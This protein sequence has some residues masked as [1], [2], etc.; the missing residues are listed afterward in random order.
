MSLSFGNFLSSKDTVI[1]ADAFALSMQQLK[2]PEHKRLAIAV[3]GGIDSMCLVYCALHYQH[4]KPIV[5]LIVD[6]GLRQ[7]S[8]TEAKWVASYLKQKGIEGHILRWQGDKPHSNIHQIARNERYKLL[9]DYCQQHNITALMVGHNR[10]DQAETVLMRIL[11]G[12]GITGLT[13]IPQKG[14]HNGI[15]ILRPLLHF[16]RAQIMA[17]M[18]EAAW[19]WIEDPS[20]HDPKYTRSVL[21]KWLMALP[22]P[23]LAVQRLDL[24]A[25]NAQR[26]ED[27]LQQQTKQFITASTA[28]IITKYGHTITMDHNAFSTAH[29]EIAL[30]VLRH[31]LL[32]VGTATMPPR[33]ERLMRLY[34]HIIAPPMA[35][36]TLCG[37]KIWV[38]QGVI[39]F[40]VAT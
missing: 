23:E 26:A 4:S 19:Q 24:L 15:A 5:A 21:R 10:N 18:K 34:Q 11:R 36:R 40:A 27:Y 17:T 35:A 16:T 28:V 38:K 22:Q 2:A 32:D 12:T 14:N 13:G 29:Q 33:L 1:S 6:H 3:S 9:T 7:E 31:L 8:G 39:H 25:H 37:C 30:R 20:N